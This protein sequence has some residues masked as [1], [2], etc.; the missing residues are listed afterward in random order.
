[1]MRTEPESRTICENDDA[2]RTAA[3]QAPITPKAPTWGSFRI[4]SLRSL[5]C[6]ELSASQVS[7]N[8]SAWM[9]PVIR[10]TNS[11]D[12]APLNVSLNPAFVIRFVNKIVKIPMTIPIQGK[13]HSIYRIFS[14]VQSACGMGIRENMAN[15]VLKLL[16][17][18]FICPPP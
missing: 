16:Y 13:K 7:I 15:A 4:S 8:P 1:M 3:A 9:P 17:N 5:S 2:K 12:A 10:I 14:S 18:F 11:A 6:Q